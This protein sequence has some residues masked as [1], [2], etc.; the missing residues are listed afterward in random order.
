MTPAAPTIS[1]I[2]AH[3]A[4]VSGKLPTARLIGIHASG[5]W[6]GPD[7]LE[8]GGQT[9][10]IR[11]CDSPLA[12]RLALREETE[13][14]AVRVLVTPLPEAEVGEDVL[15]RLARRRLF[16][17]DAWQV[18]R[19]LFQATGIDPRLT[20]RPWIADRLLELEEHPPA[21]G[22]FLDAE[23]VWPLLL[24]QAIGLAA[25]RPDLAAL[26]HWSLDAD[27]VKSFRALDAEFRGAAAEWLAGWAG[28][29]APLVL[30]CLVASDPPEALPM[31]LAAG[32]VFHPEAAGQLDRAAGR[33][34]TRF[35]GG[36]APDA[37]AMRRWS[38]AAAAVLRRLPEDD[39]GRDLLPQ[40]ADEI[41]R[42][43]GAEL[44]AHLSDV[45]PLG[46]EQ[47]LVALGRALDRVLEP[48]APD[49]LAEMEAAR[50]RVLRHALTRPGSRRRER[51]EMMVRL[52]RWLAALKDAAP[53]AARSFAEAA[54]CQAGEGSFVDW[55][56]WTLRSGD[57]VRE[58]AEAGDR[59]FAAAREVRER[60][61]ARFGALLR[62]WTA[63]GST[64][65]DVIPVEQLLE[66]VVA[67][68]AAAAPVLVI[69]VDGMSVAVARELVA[70]VTRQGWIVLR[71]AGRPQGRAGVAALPSETGYSRAGLLC[72]RI[73]RGTADTER[74]GFARHPALVARS[75]GGHLPLLFH[76]ASLQEGDG[77]NPASAVRDAIG[78]SR[79]KVV[80]VVLNAVDDLLSK[81]DQI[82]APWT[83]DTIRPLP[84][85]LDEARAARRLVVLLSDH[86]HV[87]DSG[88]VQRKQEGEARWRPDDGVL[89][90]DEVRLQGDRVTL[91]AASSPL[92]PDPPIE[93]R[94]THASGSSKIENALVALWSERVRY[95]AKQN[96]YH[97]GANPQEMIVPVVVLSAAGDPPSGW[98]EAP[99]ETPAWWDEPFVAPEPEPGKEVQAP[100]RRPR[101]AGLLFDPDED[102][103]AGEIPAWVNRLVHS[104]VFRAQR[105]L[106]GKAAP[107]QD[108][109]ARL[110]A[111]L[112][113]SGGSLPATALARAFGFAPTRLRAL[114]AAAQ[115]LLNVDGYPILTAAG[116]H[117]DEHV[118]LDR[119]LL[120]RQFDLP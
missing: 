69:V 2:R 96:G 106:A 112:D 76:K 88:T 66:T 92:P 83:A 42:E 70:Q 45:S 80:G 73:G 61:A 17:L 85:L 102:L 26:L 39:P 50:K 31:G 53:P 64:G 60:Q 59:V 15:L 91:P 89:A 9:Y 100:G 63:A 28:P 67:P 4:A 120:T 1:Q 7:R 58:L 103:A 40:R 78:D 57:P 110:L 111:L 75:R 97:G 25:G 114:L 118:E 33:L 116:E 62:D 10:L 41:L 3:V 109:L 43:L 12:L 117:D 86:G 48:A 79:R 35:L 14:G 51:I 29:T 99:V 74:T 105:K 77:G 20:A 71:E 46:Y 93:N 5:R 23:T 108:D 82:D 24:R 56:R 55:A 54:A 27:A 95:R 30:R 65:D 68:L 87:L 47:R 11:Q 37:E 104:P 98:A 22:G 16:P 49:S 21:P 34:E 38:A 107:E 115:R 13:D 119:D 84:A 101:P 90:P 52:A 94:G 18:V 113:R 44:F 72:G 8:A 32:V 19:T 36:E 81:G 6:A